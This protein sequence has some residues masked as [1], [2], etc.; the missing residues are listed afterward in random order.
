RC[1]AW[2]GHYYQFRRALV[3]SWLINSTNS[4]T[5]PG[6]NLQLLISLDS[7]AYQKVA[8]SSPSQVQVLAH[9]ECKSSCALKSSRA[10]S[11]ASQLHCSTLCLGAR[12]YTT[13]H[14]A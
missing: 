11:S 14:R 7:A 9:Y 5:L 10:K 4:L 2:V 6:P 1:C 12:V 13:M 8:F 3:V